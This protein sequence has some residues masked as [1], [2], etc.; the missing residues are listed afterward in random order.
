MN[1]GLSEEEGAKYWDMEARS[2]DIKVEKHKERYH[3]LVKYIINLT[4]PKKTDVVMEIGAGTGVASLL[5]AP[6]VK[7]VIA[8]DISG[9]AENRQRE[10]NEGWC[11]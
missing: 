8:V 1:M 10:S 4:N 6:K 5:L 11:P 9:D 3:K 7:R 2:H